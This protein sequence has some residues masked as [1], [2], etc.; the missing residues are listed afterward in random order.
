MKLSPFVAVFVLLSAIAFGT[1]INQEFQVQPGKTLNLDLKTGGDIKIEGWNKSAVSVRA[2]IDGPDREKCDVQ[3]RQTDQGIDI[4][5][6][7]LGRDNHYNTEGTFEVRVPSR[8]N[9]QIESMGGGIR[10]RNVEGEFKG[11]TMG[12]GLDLS[13]LK[14]KISLSTMGGRIDLTDSHLDGEVSTMGGEVLI[15]QV[16]GNVQG[17][18]MGGKV[19]HKK[20]SGARGKS[21]EIE[22]SSM[23]GSLNVDE[24]PDGAE[25]T[26]MGG[27]I[28]V[29]SAADHVK[30]K[31]M[32]GN[33]RIDS[34]DGWVHAETMGG[35]VAVVM[36]GNAA[37]GNREVE[38]VS[39]SGDVE[40]TVPSNLA[41]TLD[42]ELAYTKGRAGKYSIKSDFPVETEETEEWDRSDGSPRKY[43]NG[44]GKIGA[45]THRVRIRTI[46]GDIIL[47]KS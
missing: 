44:T 3:V 28:H 7:Y 15:E 10:I 13:G 40:L 4:K 30:A 27:D 23:G 31:T 35:D 32:G 29:R 14:G 22:I 20:G 17:S 47:R 21:G 8:F 33:I 18:T 24:A 19:I 42:L 43:I 2:M 12:G 38:L 39:L 36:T 6:R 46:N 5:S 26:T 16:T 25:L 41:M 11:N 9:V 37:S 45:G 1:D 34:I